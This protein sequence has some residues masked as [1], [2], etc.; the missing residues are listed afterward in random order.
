M[1]YLLKIMDYRW[2]CSMQYALQC[3]PFFY[4]LNDVVGRNIL[5]HI[6]VCLPWDCKNVMF[7]LISIL[8]GLIFCL[9]CM[10]DSLQ[11]TIAPYY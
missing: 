5:C 1:D 10:M 11:G 9:L 2:L 6:S 4:K 7:R 8:L 3:V